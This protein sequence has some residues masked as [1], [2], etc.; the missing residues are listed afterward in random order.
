MRR[1]LGLALLLLLT[2]VARLDIDTD[3]DDGGCVLGLPMCQGIGS[4]AGDPIR[5]D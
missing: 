4:G 1:S 2:A 5:G 3:D